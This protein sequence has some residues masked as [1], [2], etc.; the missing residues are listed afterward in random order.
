LW[1]WQ[2]AIWSFISTTTK[3]IAQV[4]LFIFGNIFY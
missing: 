3:A 2:G 1:P 4:I